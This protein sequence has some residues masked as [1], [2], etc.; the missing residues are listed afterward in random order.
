MQRLCIRRTLNSTSVGKLHPIKKADRIPFF[1]TFLAQKCAHK[2]RDILLLVDGSASVGYEN[3]KIVK[4]F[5]KR[6]VSKLHISI[7]TNRVS[8]IQFSSLEKTKKEFSFD[9]SE[10]VN[11]A[12]EGIGNMTFHAGQRTMLGNALEMA[13]NEVCIQQEQIFTEVI[14]FLN[15]IFHI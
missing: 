9:R 13:N 10:N 1:Q 6:L 4:T 12:H 2:Q 11:Q 14:I 5:L 3:M 15:H 8:L 7:H